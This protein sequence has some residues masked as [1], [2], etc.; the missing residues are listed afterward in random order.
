MTRYLI[1][2][3]SPFSPLI[4]WLAFLAELETLPRADPGVRDAMEE[5]RRTIAFKRGG[6][7]CRPA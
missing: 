4:E 6:C 7:L 2:P 3:P 5:A 1:D